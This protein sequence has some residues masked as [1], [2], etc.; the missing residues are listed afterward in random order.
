M[1]LAVVAAVTEEFGLGLGGKLPWHPRRL[2][3]DMAFLTAISSNDYALDKNSGKFS[4]ILTDTEPHVIFGRKTWDSLPPKFKPLRG[5]K[6][7][8]I[9]SVYKPTEINATVSTSLGEALNTISPAYVGAS[10]ILG[11]AKLYEEALSNVHFDCAFI[12]ELSEHSPMPVDV[13][14]PKESLGTDL[15]KFN[16]TRDAFLALREKIHVD[17]NHFLSPDGTCFYDNDIRYSIFAYTK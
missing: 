17:E 9:S 1:R 2:S 11:G 4:L 13:Y 12:T 16:I 6:N 7:I 15:K 14:F 10:Y 8:V 5:R 3:L